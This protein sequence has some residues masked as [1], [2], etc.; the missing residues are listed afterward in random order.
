M[1]HIGEVSGRRKCK[2]PESVAV[3]LA[4]CALRA[5][6]SVVAAL[7]LARVALA[8]PVARAE[9]ETISIRN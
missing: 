5:V 2:A 6:G 4:G 1:V 3:L 7:A 8:C 9:L